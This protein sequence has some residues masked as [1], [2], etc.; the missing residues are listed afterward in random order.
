M[1]GFHSAEGWSEGAA[2]T[3]ELPSFPSPR[4][5]PGQ[6]TLPRV[7]NELVRWWKRG[8][9]AS[10]LA[11]GAKS[12]PSASAPG[13]RTIPQCSRN[14]KNSASV[15]SISA[16]SST[17]PPPAPRSPCSSS[18][19]L[20]ERKFPPPRPHRHPATRSPTHPG[21]G[22][23]Y[24]RNHHNWV[25]HSWRKATWVGPALPKARGPPANLFAGV[26]DWSE[27]AAGTTELS[28]SGS[29]PTV[30][31]T[32]CIVKTCQAQSRSTHSTSMT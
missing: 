28:C 25:P 7:P 16:S 21:T 11:G 27:G 4:F 20:P 5:N 9:P 14:L 6:P 15:S 12:S 26:G 23:P 22:G 8:A 24:I 18:K 3:T 29:Y 2:G 10:S 13:G 30:R 1:G 31:V 32:R 17:A 19:S